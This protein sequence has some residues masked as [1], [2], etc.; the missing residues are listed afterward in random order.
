M[1][2]TLRAKVLGLSG[3]AAA[4][5]VGLGAISLT[6]Q[7]AVGDLLGHSLVVNEALS[8]HQSADMM[9][10]ALRGDVLS[11][12]LAKEPAEIARISKDVADHAKE[13]RDQIAANRQLPLNDTV[14]SALAKAEPLE[15]AYISKAEEIFKTAATDRAKALTLLPDYEKAFEA[16]EEELGGITDKIVAEL[17]HVREMRES[18][19]SNSLMA[20][21]SAAVVALTILLVTGFILS[22]RM[23]RPVRAMGAALDSMAKGDWTAKV[24]VTSGDEIEDMAHSLSRMADAVRA[25]LLGVTE[26]AAALEKSSTELNTTS[27]GMTRDAE[28]TAGQ[29]GNVSTAADQV[30]TS[31]ATVA[32]AATELSQ[33]VQEIAS[34]TSE[35]ARV[36]GE[37]VRTTGE[38]GVTITRLGDSSQQIGEVVKT[39][40][41]IAE[42]A[43]LL[44]LN[45]TIEAASA[46]EAGKGFAVVAGEVKSL[47]RQTADATE[48][49]SRRVTAIQT[50]AAA[51]VEAI[52]RISAI[53]EKINQATQT[54][55]SAVEEQ[56]ATTGEIS[57]TVQDAAR[58]GSD[59]ATAIGSVATAA[60][61]TTGG[62]RQV[63]Q[64]ARDLAQVAAD[65][66]GLIAQLRR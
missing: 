6:G 21:A 2:L 12:Q 32:S 11:L 9:H 10:D 23:V 49:I 15:E 63:S 25:L 31:I 27:A 57:R 3:L 58:G 55:A 46:G 45:A 7:L 64:A 43:N 8:H 59:I 39:I 47:A 19:Y 51:S 44:A 14:K 26:R 66:R 62:A 24:D 65:L 41:A 52:T 50:D 34:Q 16:A 28:T 56:S 4:L 1:R 17:N 35:A 60:Q 53:I 48:D 38:V 54:I 30:S 20:T 40:T 18:V 61:A 13:F 37:A 36:A 29:A 42:Q 22:G 5:L 33:S